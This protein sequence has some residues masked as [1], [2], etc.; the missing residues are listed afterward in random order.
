MYLHTA[1]CNRK[2][3]P[4]SS[5]HTA[6]RGCGCRDSMC[7]QRVF[8]TMGVFARPAFASRGVFAHVSL[9]RPLSS[10]R[11]MS[12]PDLSSGGVFARE[13]VFAHLS[14]R[15][16]LRAPTCL[17]GLH[18]TCVREVSSPSSL[19]D[20]SSRAH[21]SSPH[22]DAC[23]CPTCL[24]TCLRTHTCLCDDACLRPTCLRQFSSRHMASL[25]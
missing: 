20:V 1:C 21:M 24:W 6:S 14:E 3:R 19:W 4:C 23:P 9:P 25:L 13:R 15:R 18:Q 10:R 2:E 11:I 5:K 16:C 12:S 8:A 22:D 7:R 17:L